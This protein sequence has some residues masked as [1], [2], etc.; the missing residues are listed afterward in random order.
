MTKL[1]GAALTTLALSGCA[2]GDFVA[3]KPGADPATLQRDKFECDRMTRE[4]WV[5]PLI[6]APLAA[7]AAEQRAQKGFHECLEVR[8]YTVYEQPKVM[9]GLEFNADLRVVAVRPGLPADAAGIKVGDRV[10]RL[11]G[12]VMQSKKDV[13]V[14]LLGKNAGDSVLVTFERNGATMELTSTLVAR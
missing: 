9:L 10:M 12:R 3:V 11:D 14:V 6:V 2:T 5:A 13:S 4:L 1:L 7:A 8:G